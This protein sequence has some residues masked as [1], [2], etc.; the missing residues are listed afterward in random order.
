MKRGIEKPQKNTKNKDKNRRPVDEP[1]SAPDNIRINGNG[2]VGVGVRAPPWPVPRLQNEKMY[3][4]PKQ[5]EP[6]DSIIIQCQIQNEPNN[7]TFGLVTGNGH[8]DSNNL[9]CQLD[10]NEDGTLQITTVH[11]GNATVVF[12]GETKQFYEGPDFQMMFVLRQ[13]FDGGYGLNVHIG[14]S[15]SYLSYVPLVHDVRSIRFISIRGD[16]KKL[17]LGFDFGETDT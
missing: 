12:S 7:L 13:A 6:H 4:L 14:T 8:P 11:Q 15:Y 2:N 3:L 1:Y 17:R 5:L 10:M 16:I 9:A